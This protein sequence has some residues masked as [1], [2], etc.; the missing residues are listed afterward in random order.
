MVLYL[1][2]ANPSP[3]HPNRYGCIPAFFSSPIYDPT[4][5]NRPVAL[6]MDLAMLPGYDAQPTRVPRVGS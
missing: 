4:A 2:D 5:A 3:N 6:H 1:P